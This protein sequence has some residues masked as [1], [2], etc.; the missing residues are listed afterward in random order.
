MKKIAVL[1]A[2][3]F[4]FSS[5]LISLHPLYTADTIVYDSL[6]KGEW[7]DNEDNDSPD[8]WIFRPKQASIN[9]T[10]T[11]DDGS[12]VTLRDDE[13]IDG[14]YELA[15]FSEEGQYAYD[16]VL[17]KLG[18]T[19]FLDVFPDAPIDDLETFKQK[20]K[21]PGLS[22]SEEDENFPILANYVATHNFYKVEFVNDKKILIYPFDGERLEDLVAQRKIRI[23]HESVNDNF[24]ITASTEELQKF[25]IKYAEDKKTFEDPL[26]LVLE[27]S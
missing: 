18:K 7:V 9:M 12:T 21:T 22:F 20:E 4:I 27:Q 6:L 11:K 15:H 3:T 24:V 19:Y 2:M 5:C 13:G 23:K 25:I 17:L 8:V 26:E 1:I 10:V 14:H 16:A